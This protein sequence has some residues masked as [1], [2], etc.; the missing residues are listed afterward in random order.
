MINERNNYLDFLKTFG[1]ALIILAHIPIPSWLLAIRN[2]DV[3]LMV[4]VSGCLTNGSFERSESIF[5]YL[6][7]RIFRLLIPTWIFLS[8]Y[9][10]LLYIFSKNG[11][12]EKNIILK[13]YLL[14][15]DSIGYV[16]IIRI[17]LLCAFSVPFL[18]KVNFSKLY[19]W[20]LIAFIYILYEFACK[21][22]LWMDY[23]IIE[24]TVYYLIPYGIVLLFGLNWKRFAKKEKKLFLLFSFFVFIILQVL[25]FYKFGVYCSTQNYKYPPRHLFLA[26]AFLYI[27]LLM[28]FES[29]LNF[30]GKNKVIVFISKSTL[31]I[32]LW[33]IL[34]LRLT[35]HLIPNVH[36]S[37]KYIFVV[38]ISLLIVFIQ[39]KILDVIE[40]KWKI[41]IL[42]VFRG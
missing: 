13:S 19:T 24:C 14:Q 41:P 5:A 11:L 33:H 4:F 27:F 34:V 1:L 26:H 22:R 10:I 28:Q 6:K 9:F 31:W 17:Y 21:Y 40:T 20:G 8:L 16:W 25:C 23:R 32:Y 15:D 35:E 38:L 42:K 39:N 36:W 29:K 12:P 37:L 30:L 7:K 3:P 18:K 2:F